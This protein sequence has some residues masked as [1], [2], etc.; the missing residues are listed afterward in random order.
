MNKMFEILK[1]D[2]KRGGFMMVQPCSNV[3]DIRRSTKY[4]EFQNLHFNKVDSKAPS[5]F[6][7]MFF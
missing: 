5:N 7:F 2:R 4:L 1:N 6:D 3:T